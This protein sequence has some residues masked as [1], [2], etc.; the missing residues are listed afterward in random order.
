MIINI[1]K[2]ELR[3][4]VTKAT[5]FSVIMMALIFMFVGRVVGSASEET[6]KLPV[7]SVVDLDNSP[8]S[9]TIVNS[10]ESNAE[11]A[12]SGSDI[13]EA[14]QRLNEAGGAAMVVINEGFGNSLLNGNQGEVKVEWYIKG[15]GIV[16]SI[17]TAV[18]EQLISQAQRELSASMITENSSLKPDLVLDPLIITNVTHFKDK[19]ITNLSPTE[20]N[21]M[22]TSQSMAIP[23]AIMMLVIM[24]GNSL[25]ASMGMEKENKTLETLLTMPIKKSYIITGK[26][27]ASA[28]VSL[29]MALVYMIGFSYYLK[30]FSS[31]AMNPADYGFS[32]G[33]I[34]Y[35][36][37]GVSVF[38]ALLAALAISIVLG[39]F[40]TNYRSAQTLSFPLIGVAMF[41]MFMNLFQDF[42]T[43]SL[44]LKALVFIIPFSHPMMAM[45]ELLLGNYVLV[46]SGIAYM[47]VFT[48]ATIAVAT[49]IFNTDRLLTGRIGRRRL[50]ERGTF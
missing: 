23:I 9:M 1:I 13:D 26:I 3:E 32:L 43:M 27:V 17:P 25:I 24:A 2:K 6:S 46:I 19:T 28:I 20:L 45:K 50:Q 4:L 18:L 37:I 5:F 8:V 12:Y 40:S 29:V 35:I 48:V 34:D 16:E 30:A 31:A 47:L 41:A 42:G 22:L 36:L 44:P 33:I 10:L 21:Q 15:M 11:I 14:R 49:W 7:I 39:S 38:L